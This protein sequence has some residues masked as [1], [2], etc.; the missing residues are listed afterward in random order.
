[1]GLLLNWGISVSWMWPKAAPSC[2]QRGH[3][4]LAPTASLVSSAAAMLLCLPTQTAVIHSFLMLGKVMLDEQLTGL[5]EKWLVTDGCHRT[6]RSVCCKGR[7][8]LRCSLLYDW[9]FKAER[10]PLSLISVPPS[11][12]TCNSWRKWGK[13]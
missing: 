5:F 6:D 8:S 4:A 10:S 12:N 9:I 13:Y 1:M 3:L 7:K 2:G 11:H